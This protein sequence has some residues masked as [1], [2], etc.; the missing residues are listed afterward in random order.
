VQWQLVASGCYMWCIHIWLTTKGPAAL[1]EGPKAAD[2]AR[3]IGSNTRTVLFF[4]SVCR[5]V[6]QKKHFR[7]KKNRAANLVVL[8][9]DC[10]R[11]SGSE[12]G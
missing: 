7:S 3:F 2:L 10:K 12:S 4:W 9:S 1:S 8:L 6:T 11:E 5:H